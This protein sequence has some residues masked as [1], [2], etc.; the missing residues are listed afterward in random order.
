MST[1]LPLIVRREIL[2]SLVDMGSRYYSNGDQLLQ[3]G[4]TS[5]QPVLTADFASCA[6]GEDEFHRW[7]LIECAK[8]W[9]G[10]DASAGV[11]LFGN[12]DGYKS[13]L[14]E[15]LRRERDVAGYGKEFYQSTPS[16]SWRCWLSPCHIADRKQFLENTEA[17]G[18][19]VATVQQEI[20]AEQTNEAR[21]HSSWSMGALGGSA[22][23]IIAECKR[24]LQSVLQAD[25]FNLLHQEAR[26]GW[27]VFSK[28][29]SRFRDAICFQD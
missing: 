10:T 24:L 5:F 11:V 21:L 7:Y 17:Y 26:S 18:R 19:T 23:N 28:P 14:L 16:Q 2:A 13:P 3:A 8:E 22:R 4:F 15:R 6:E 20:M 1:A 25:G 9:I 27:L 12:G 29:I